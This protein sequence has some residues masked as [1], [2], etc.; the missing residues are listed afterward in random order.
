MK[1]ASIFAVLLILTL[2]VFW[3]VWMNR[4]SEKII[5]AVVPIAVAALIG[6]AL[7]VFV[8][9]GESPISEVFP[10]SFLY[11]IEEK[12]PADLP[13]ML[14]RHRFTSMLF[15]PN[16]L[17]EVHPEYFKDPNDTN[18]GMLYHHL[19]QKSIIDWIGTLY[20]GSWQAEILHFDLPGSSELRFQ[21]AAVP[22]EPSKILS[23]K[24][25]EK[26]LKENKFGEIRTGI[27]P[28]IALPPDTRMV[29]TPPE[30]KNGSLDRGEILLENRFCRV[31]IQTEVSSWMRGAG[32]YKQLAG[33]SDEENDHL[34]TATYIV[35]FRAE[36]TRWL[37]GH[38]EMPK[39]KRWARQLAD[40]LKVQFDEQVIWQ[41]TKEDYLFWKQ[42]EQFGHGEAQEG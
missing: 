7:V 1:A 31:S 28:Q 10:A 20:R 41:K 17:H 25:I 21:P 23:T 40:E 11:S 30:H 42:T 2:G 15:A 18:G 16:A 9:G 39:Y 38:P 27:S 26:L 24:D 12:M 6:V 32:G 13:W 37:S 8:F 3:L 29:I 19:L 14:S 4:A 22:A 36:F 33:I 35:R 34:G 5:T